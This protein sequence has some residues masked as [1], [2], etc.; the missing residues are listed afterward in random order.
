MRG[1][2]H[3]VLGG[4]YRSAFKGRGIEFSE[5]R[6][7]QIGDDV[8]TIDWNVTARTDEPYVK[9]FE[10]EREQTLLLVV[11]VSA[12]G[13][14]GS[15]GQAKREVA[16]ELCAAIGFSAMEAGDRIGL[17]LYSDRVERYV[18]PKKGRRHVLR[19][20]R[21]VFA[22][23]AV[24][25]G[26][27]LAAALDH[28]LHVQKRRTVTLIV[29]DFLDSG[30]DRTLRV[31]GSRH[32]V[33]AI[34]LRDPRERELPAVGLLRLMDYETNE[35]VMV[36]TFSPASRRAYAEAAARH[37][38]ATEARL[39]AARVDVVPLATDGDPIS[40]L[41]GYFQRRNRHRAGSVVKRSLSPSGT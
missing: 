28:L 21:D 23:E 17:M 25:T 1:L 30:F 2:V 40:A 12:S 18:P 36:D 8:R 19:L 13:E 4:E 33:V 5:V 20:V 32:D 11:D 41:S 31:A 3:D 10:E 35:V 9:V 37:A 22:H 27:D 39:R 34:W 24:G 15:T 26:T 6:P 29:S 16:A 38:A 14:F 7:Y